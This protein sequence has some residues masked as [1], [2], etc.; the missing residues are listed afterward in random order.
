M[1]LVQ[2]LPA[3]V[4]LAACG[5][6]PQSPIDLDEGDSTIPR[7]V[8][9][10]SAGTVDRPKYVIELPGEEVRFLV[11]EFGSVG[12]L[13]VSQT[14]VSVLDEPELDEASPAV[15]FHALSEDPIP[16]DLLWLHEDLVHQGRVPPLEDALAGR[17]AGWA[18]PRAQA[19]SQPC[20]NSTFKDRHCAHPSYDS[21]IC[22][23]NIEG[24]RLNH[25]SQARRFKAGLC[26][27]NGGARSA[28]IRQNEISCTS[29]DNTSHFI[30]G[31]PEDQP[32]GTVFVATTYLSYVWWR[33]SNAP[34]R[35]FASNLGPTNM[36]VYDWALRYSRDPC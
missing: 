2:F 26:V 19:L 3:A 12:I 1:K 20:R 8:T 32:Y 30:W 22:W 16:S 15:V 17:L 18:R 35:Y 10:T 4:V 33:P 6:P 13:G 7:D 28:L 14:G 29:F 21:S 25:V 9:H 23:L 31:E 27:Q 34:L 5:G 11:D 24:Y 36:G